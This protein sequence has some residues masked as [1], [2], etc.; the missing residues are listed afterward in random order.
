MRRVFKITGAF[1]LSAILCMNTACS[2]FPDGNINNEVE[3]DNRDVVI[4]GDE[5]KHIKGTLVGDVTIDADV[6][7]PSDTEWKQYKMISR[8]IS[9]E[10]ADEHVKRFADN[11]DYKEQDTS[12]YDPSIKRFYYEYD[13]GS[14]FVDGEDYVSYRTDESMEM[15]YHRFVGYR[16]VDDAW[17]D[18]EE[19]FPQK[20]L[21]G[22]DLNAAI[23]NVKDICRKLDIEINE[24][25]PDVY[26]M[27]AVSMNKL[28]KKIND[29]YGDKPGDEGALKE[30]SEDDEVYYI[31]YEMA[32]KG[33][34]ME[35]ASITTESKFTYDHWVTAAVGRDG[36]KEFEA[37]YLYDIES[38][39]E[40]EGDLCSVEEAMD[41]VAAQL[42]YLT[43]RS[44]YSISDI[45]LKYMGLLNDDLSDYYSRPYWVFT[46]SAKTV[47]YKDGEE[48]ETVSSQK[49][50]VD[51]VKKTFYIGR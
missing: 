13:D 48:V 30:W 10:E 37:M 25:E 33:T 39:Q 32:L 38:E 12:K 50:C 29:K 18:K 6:K 51:A 20:S 1:L 31:I 49:L 17:T 2:L 22:C 8:Q 3:N 16:R 43:G 27:D 11:R 41:V 45:E 47:S 28:V 35:G 4:T 36:I 44:K 42:Q 5:S 23:E 46:T 7:I 19:A 9:K 21:S 14:V 24:D 15:E 26:V 40:L 34:N